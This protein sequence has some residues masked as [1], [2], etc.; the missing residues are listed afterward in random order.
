MVSLWNDLA[1]SVGQELLDIADKSPIVAIKSFKV[2]EFQ[3]K[4]WDARTRLP[5]QRTRVRRGGTQ[6]RGRDATDRASVPHR[7]TWRLPNWANA[8]E[9][10]ADEA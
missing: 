4:T 10:G 5:G 7:A 3:R 1:T 9:I 6:R 2:G 8:V